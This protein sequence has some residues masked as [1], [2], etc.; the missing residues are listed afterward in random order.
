MLVWCCALLGA[1]ACKT[2]APEEER[3]PSYDDIQRIF[4]QSCAGSTCHISS[5]AAEPP[6][7]VDLRDGV[8]HGNLVGRPAAANPAVMLVAPGSPEASYLLCTVDPACATRTGSLMPPSA[9]L[10]P[11]TVEALR[12]WIAAGASPD[13]TPTPS[14]DAGGDTV[15]P[16]FAG[17]VS[18]T[19]TGEHEVALAWAPAVDVTPPSRLAYRIYVATSPGG[20]DYAVPRATVTGASSAVVTNLETAIRYYFVVRAVDEA[21]NADDN[22]VERDALTTD[23]TPPE[24]GGVVDATAAGG[25]ALLVSWTLATD[26]A[27]A[28]GAIRYRVYL[29]TAP[30]AQDFTMPAAVT[31]GGATSTTLSGLLPSTTYHVVVRAVDEAGNEDQNLVERAAATGDTVPPTFAGASGATGGANAVTLT[32]AAATDD[33]TPSSEIVYLIYRSTV[34]GGESFAAPTY[35]TPPGATSFAA[36]GLAVSTTYYFVV[37]ARD[38]AG[39]TDLNLV[40]R[41]ATT[42]AVA[43]TMP[44]TFAGATSAVSTGASSIRLT[45]SAA[46]DNASASNQIVYLVYQASSAGGQNFAAP[47]YTTLAGVTSYEVTGLSPSTTYH[48]VVRARDQ[49]GNI[50]ANTAGVN[51]ATT[52]DV[53]APAFGGVATASAVGAS[54][55]ALSWA[56]ATDDVTASNQIVYLVYQAS[57]SGGQSFA[58]PTFTTMSGATGFVVSGLAPATTYYFVVRARD[59]AGNVDANTVERSAATGSDTTPPTFAGATGATGVSAS[60]LEV[61]WAPATDNVSSSAQ[62]VYELYASTTSGGQTF[63]NPTATTPAGVTSHTLTGLLAS[64]TYHVV[65]RARDEAGNLDGNTVQVNATTAPDTTRPSFAGVSAAAA[66]SPSTALLSWSAATDDVTPAAQLVYLVYRSSTPGGQNFAAATVTTS[67]GA[68]SVT[69]GGLSPS[70]TYYYVVRARDAAGNVDLNTIERSAAQPA[71]TVSF[72]GAVQP[73]FTGNC[74]S[75]GCHAGPMPAQGMNLSAGA[76]YAGLVN[77]PSA[78]CGP[79]LRVRPGDATNSYLMWKLQG[80]GPCFSGTQMPKGSPPLS[81]AQQTTIR[82]WIN[83]GALNN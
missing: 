77:V 72:S 81:A 55:V 7:S 41:S 23:V 14:P 56:P 39:N 16:V 43:D 79:T 58:S 51:A 69:V 26:N 27:S 12:R 10:S 64:T 18:A 24:F 48:F 73:I 17:L 25:D 59:L 66:S 2:V 57:S 60:S 33:L 5:S 9:P 53:V 13:T 29:A 35:V 52:G 31:S 75:I 20:Q 45:W 67:A 22:V 15:A 50:D 37:R 6:Q 8:S 82:T 49:A 78:E 68:T 21:G 4:D 34:P 28:P 54:S 70:M 65:V 62:I 83:E 80:S 74:A 32:W 42:L 3:A 38:L 63:G 47:T 40:E 36:G 46:T 19:A 44:P 71:S 76:A 11:N 1:T 30:G 61:T